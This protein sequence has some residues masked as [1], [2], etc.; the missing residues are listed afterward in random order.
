MGNIISNKRIVKL[1]RIEKEEVI[2]VENRAN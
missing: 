2:L 1:M